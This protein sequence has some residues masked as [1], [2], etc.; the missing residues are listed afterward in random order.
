MVH[1]RVVRGK[2]LGGHTRRVSMV[3]GDVEPEPC[4]ERFT[5]TLDLPN[6]FRMIRSCSKVFHLKGD[7]EFLEQLSD[8]LGAVVR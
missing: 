2:L 6:C 3:V 5:V 1:M 7:A 8:E 4:D